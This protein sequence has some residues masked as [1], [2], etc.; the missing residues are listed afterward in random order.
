MPTSAPLPHA[1]PVG[2]WFHV[3]MDVKLHTTMGS[4]AIYID[5]MTTAALKKENVSTV[6][7]DSTARKLSKQ[8]LEKDNACA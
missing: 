5:D 2:K 3:R 8:T 6:T 1:V 7:I 4:F